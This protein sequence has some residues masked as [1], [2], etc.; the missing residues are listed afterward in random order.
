MRMA[1]K[2]YTGVDIPLFPTML[3]KGLIFQGEGS[4]VPVE[5]HHTPTGA[6][7]TSQPYFSPTLRSSIRQET[8]VPHP[9]SSPYTNVADEVASTCMDVKYGGAA[10]T[11][12]G[13][14]AGQGSGNID[15]MPHDSPLP[16]VHTLGSDEGRMQ[17]NELMDFVTKL[18]DRVIA[19]ETDL[20]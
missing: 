9:S 11:V 4:T 6:P 17:H 15:T 3:V 1:S 19:L 12:T 10:T 7:S 16:R 20:T 5:F 14:E 2:G 8:E 13:L 18:S